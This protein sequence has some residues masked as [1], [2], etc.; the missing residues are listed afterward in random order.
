MSLAS[1]RRP[2]FLTAL[3][4]LLLSALLPAHAQNA[5]QLDVPYVPTPDHVVA[6]MLEMANVNSDDTVIDLGSGD[7]RIAIA[8]VRDRGARSAL[9]IDLDPERIREAEANAEAAG[10]SDKVS[11]EQ[12]D[13]FKK[14]ISEATVLTMYLLPRVNLRLRPVILDTLK[15]GTRVVSHAFSM[16]EWQADRSDYIGGSYVYL[17]IVPAKVDGRWEVN[18]GNGNFT[19]DLQQQ[20]QQVEGTAQAGGLQNAVTGSLEGEVLRFNVGSKLYMGKVEGDRITALSGE[21]AV[22]NWSARRT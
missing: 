22:S 21:G 11:F 2:A 7:G 9:G 12:G 3:P 18:D 5:P 6:R 15:P 8:A 14:D 16:D 20:F 4:L 10:V 1:V 13:L 17:W 19:L